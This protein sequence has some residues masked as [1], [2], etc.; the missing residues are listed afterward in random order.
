MKDEDQKLLVTDAEL[1]YLDSL[2]W[3]ERCQNC[4]MLLHYRDMYHEP[5]K[6]LW[7]CDPCAKICVK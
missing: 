3:F 1:D 2:L 5:A 7:L 4:S 6:N